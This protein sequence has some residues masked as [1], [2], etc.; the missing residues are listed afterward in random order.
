MD[1]VLRGEVGHR[2]RPPDAVE[3]RRG[4]GQPPLAHVVVEALQDAAVEIGVALVLGRLGEPLGAHRLEHAHGVV[5]HLLP[6]LGVE[7]REEIQGL[8]VP[9]PP[10][11]V[12]QLPEAG[13][14]RGQVDDGREGPEVRVAGARAREDVAHL[15]A[16]LAEPRGARLGAGHR[17]LES[18]QVLGKEGL[19]AGPDGDPTGFAALLQDLLVGQGDELAEDAVE[20]LDDGGRVEA[21]PL[22]D[23]DR[24]VLPR[25]GEHP[26]A[27][28][29]L[30]DGHGGHGV[31]GALVGR[32]APGLV[33]R[34]EHPQVAARK[35][36]VVGH[37]EQAVVPVQAGG[38]EDDAD[39]VL[40]AVLEAQAA[41]GLEDRV[42]GLV[43]QA[44][45][46]DGDGGA[47]GPG[48]A[49]LEGRHE[50][51]V[52]PHEAQQRQDAGVAG[53][54]PVQPPQGL[55]EDVHALVVELVAARGHQDPR[56]GGQRPS[57]ELRG[58]G[59]DPFAG[60]Q[61]R[62]SRFGQVRNA[63]HVEAVGRH[64][65]GRASQE[66]FRLQPRDVAHRG[67]AVGLPRAGGLQGIPG[68]AVVG[69]R[70]PLGRDVLH[71]GVDVHAR[72]GQHPAQDGGVQ[73]E[74]RA[75]LGDRFL[76]GQQ[77]RPADPVVKQGDGPE[78]LRLDLEV[79]QRLDDLAAGVAEHDPLDVVPAAGDGIDAIV[80]PELEQQL[81]LVV[82]LRE[83]H[84]D[85]PRLARHLP[86]AEA[87][88]EILHRRVLPDGEPEG[89]VGFLE[90]PVVLQVRPQQ[91]VTVPE[92]PHRGGDLAADGGI[93]LADLVAGLPAHLEQVVFAISIHERTPDFPST[94]P[95]KSLRIFM[96]W[97]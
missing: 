33:V 8:G 53:H 51:H 10:E 26:G 84:Q 20:A 65:V 17:P 75:G 42:R 94:L 6:E 1:A 72:C 39:A 69:A 31:G 70:L 64:H 87:A 43:A 92:G 4:L 59:E 40:G 32:V 50:V 37:V 21:P 95:E 29:R 83:V 47:L 7:Q 52:A 48:G 45:R 76:H 55:Q 46:R 25:R 58:G 16:G 12:G 93:D 88:G 57:Q 13:D 14:L 62:G 68:G 90:L 28:A 15:L 60:P 67:E 63:R 49:G 38:V 66:V 91:H 41:A 77:A 80:L 11:V 24:P 81:V 79:V 86:S 36:V 73:R 22:Q 35:E 71:L 27:E 97:M 82:L 34:R 78:P 30:V 2:R 9:G 19:P 44:V 85:D 5:A 61:G 23:P 89:L 54:F 96:V 56:V 18:P 3:S 74:N